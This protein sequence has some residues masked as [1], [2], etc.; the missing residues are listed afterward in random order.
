MLFPLKRI[1]EISKSE[2]ENI[3]EFQF[4][5]MYVAVC[6]QM[7]RGDGSYDRPSVTVDD[8]MPHLAKL[9]PLYR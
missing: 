5:K 7:K 3:D 4:A 8:I 2:R 6:R 9:E 1:K